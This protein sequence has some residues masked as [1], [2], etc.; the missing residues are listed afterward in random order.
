[1][2]T[3]S[4]VPTAIRIAQ[5][6]GILQAVAMLASTTAVSVITL[7][8]TALAGNGEVPLTFG[9]IVVL[10]VGSVLVGILILAA[11]LLIGRGD[12][13]PRLALIALEIIV[14]VGAL[15][16]IG[17]AVEITAPLALAIIVCL[18]LSSGW[19]PVTDRSRPDA[20]R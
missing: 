15:A 14:L 11:A 4:R 20:T 6:L 13:A 8:P 17:I 2:T 7:Q 9:D 1:M 5:A 19:R 3:S 18:L 10:V 12:A 16:F